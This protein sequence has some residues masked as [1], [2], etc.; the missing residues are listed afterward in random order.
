MRNINQTLLSKSRTSIFIAHR[1]V[2]HGHELGRAGNADRFA[3]GS[4]KTVADADL[5]IV[6][7]DGRVA[8]QGTHASLMARGEEGVYRRMWEQQN[9]DIAPGG[10]DLKE[11]EEIEGRE[12]GEVQEEEVRVG[13]GAQ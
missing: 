7:R 10:R 13:R 11:L 6:L 9:A 4:L 5:I 1:C 8:E 12:A 3:P 2:S